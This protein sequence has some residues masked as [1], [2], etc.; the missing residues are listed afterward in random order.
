MNLDDLRTFAEVARQDSL[1]QAADALHASPSA[2][3]KAIR[4]LE[5]ALRTPLFDR[6]GGAM[7]LNADGQR[8]LR[9]AQALLALAQDTVAEFRDTQVPSHVRVHGPPLLLW[10]S[11]P[12]LSAAL[13][14]LPGRRGVHLTAAHEDSALASLA[15]G[16]A[17]I[18]VVTGVAANAATPAGTTLLP[19]GRMTLQLAAHRGHPLLAGRQDPAAAYRLQDLAGVDFVAPQH[20]PFCG[21]ARGGRADGWREDIAARHVRYWTDDLPALL[22]LVLAGA[23]VAYLP[24][25]L[26]ASLGLQ[27][28]PLQDYPYPCTEEVFLAWQPAAAP[29]WLAPL[30]DAL[31]TAG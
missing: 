2:V 8:L 12:A 25:T 11:A 14:R 26:L 22:S 29:G 7:R 30:V 20:S 23:A 18:A 24:D 16:E 4:R 21:L 28:I 6:S 3:S 31:A 13:D 9:R 1:R 17:D 19:L 10:R 27:P 5:Q 15:R